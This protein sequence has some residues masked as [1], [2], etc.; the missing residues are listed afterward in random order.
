MD[1]APRRS[2]D[3]GCRCRRG[4]TSAGRSA[5]PCLPRARQKRDRDFR[6]GTAAPLSRA[7]RRVGR[8][9]PRGAARIL[10]H[11]PWTVHRGRRS[12][13][14][15]RHAIDLV[16]AKNSGGTATYGKIAAARALRLSVILLR[17]PTLPAVPTVETVEE[18]LTWLDHALAL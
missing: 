5:P 2:L 3:R 13:V 15:G 17:R 8:A 12:G 11:R 1:A 16:V 18:A 7:Q 6:A 14:A 4:S 10:R 9:A